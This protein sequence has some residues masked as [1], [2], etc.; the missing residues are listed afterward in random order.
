[1]HK[2]ATLVDMYEMLVLLEE[3]E[4][5]YPVPDQLQLSHN[6]TPASVLRAALTELEIYRRAFELVKK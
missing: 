5:I 6:I 3:H 2:G 1:M 4:R